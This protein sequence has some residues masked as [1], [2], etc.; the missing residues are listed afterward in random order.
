MGHMLTEL[1]SLH[2]GL[3]RT[4]LQRDNKAMQTMM[5][6]TILSLVLSQID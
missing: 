2:P 5:V 6:S 1:Q 4:E 3:M